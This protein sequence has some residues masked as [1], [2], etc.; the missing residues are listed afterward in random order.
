MIYYHRRGAENAED[1]ILFCFPLRGRKAKTGILLGLRNNLLKFQY[2]FTI[3]NFEL[4]SFAVPS[5]AKE[6]IFNFSAF[7]PREKRAVEHY[8]KYVIELTN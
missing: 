6:I 2:S 7:A 3:T 5:T 8:E 1:L 4:F